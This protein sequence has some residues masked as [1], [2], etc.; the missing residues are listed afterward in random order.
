MKRSFVLSVLIH[1]CALGFLWADFS[2]MQ[3]QTAPLTPVPLIIDL[4]NVMVA[5]KTNLP[6]AVKKKAPKQKPAPKP[7]AVQ[8]KS[9]PKPTPPKPVETKPLKQAATAIEKPKVTE[10]P[11]SK[12]PAPKKTQP[13]PK[14]P[15]AEDSLKSLLASVDKIK[16]PMNTP[17]PQSVPNQAAHDGIDGGT[18]GSL[19]QPLSISEQ[20]LIASKLRGCW[21]VDA[22]AKGIEDM[23]IEIKAFVAKNGRVQDVRILNM[24]N[25]PVFQSVAESARRAVYICDN[26]GA[27]SPFQILAEKHKSNYNSWKEI[28]VRFNPIDGGVY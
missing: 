7:K 6:P 20:D 11:K 12:T 25:N 16:K 23:I 3:K 27:D 10:K 21:N 24:K 1:V 18:H 28:Y 17:T 9:P 4:K 26:L 19:T 13:T 8:T 14:K 22:G 5:E 2:F 15:S